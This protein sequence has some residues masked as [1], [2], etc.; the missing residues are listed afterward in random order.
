MT[1]TNDDGSRQIVAAVLGRRVTRGTLSKAF[2][3]VEDRAHW[4]NPV[5]AV[6]DVA[7]DY[8]RA[9]LHEAIVFFTGS[10]PT[11]TVVPGGTLPGCRYR[12]TAAGYYAA[13]GA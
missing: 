5:N 2:R 7:N 8:D 13:I 9:L 4:K 11:F 12:V 6:V 3:R 10:L 1:T